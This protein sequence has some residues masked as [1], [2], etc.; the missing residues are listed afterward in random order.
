M[1]LAKS[2]DKYREIR[3]RLEAVES[4]ITVLLEGAYNEA[5]SQVKT[6]QNQSNVDKNL[7]KS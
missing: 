7:V 2:I 1:A 3:S 6:T 4:Q 5:K